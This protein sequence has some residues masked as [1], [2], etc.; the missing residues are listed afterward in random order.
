[1]AR[2]LNVRFMEDHQCQEVAH[3]APTRVRRFWPAD[4]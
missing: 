3:L 2:A 1:M 4:L